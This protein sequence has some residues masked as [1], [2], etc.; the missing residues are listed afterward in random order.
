MKIFQKFAYKILTLITFYGTTNPI[1]AV[2][3]VQMRGGMV[4]KSCAERKISTSL[5][6]TS[7]VTQRTIE[8]R[9][10]IHIEASNAYL[11][12]SRAF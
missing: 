7:T 4:A 6:C 9:V 10:H 5:L 1:I 2:H 8:S 3:F 12:A 11:W